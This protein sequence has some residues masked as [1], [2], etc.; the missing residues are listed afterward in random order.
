LVAEAPAVGV[1]ELGRMTGEP[2]STVQRCLVTLHEAGWLA[3]VEKAGHR[4]WR[5]TSKLAELARR[6]DEF[7][8]LPA[9]ALPAMK[10][11]CEKTRETIHLLRRDGDQVVLISKLDS[12]QTL[13]TVR[14]IGVRAALHVSSNGKAILAAMSSEALG[15]Y[16]DRG[17]EPMTDR[18]I[19]DGELL[20]SDLEKTR[21]RGF[22]LSDGE[23]DPNVRAVAAAIKDA[24]GEPV[25][26]ISISCPAV[27]LPDERVAEY[28]K[29]VNE[30]A[31]HIGELLKS[32]RRD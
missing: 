31:A 29:L 16:I 6:T 1:S 23:L 15:R 10:K 17:L 11:L 20:A 18:S 19:T 5:A 13:R 7:A 30:A 21:R 26:G 9:L 12:P 25:A 4:K 28:G 3:P 14:S 24:D 2:K 22:A 32:R 8:D 27:R